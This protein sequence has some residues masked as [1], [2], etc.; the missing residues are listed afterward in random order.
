VVL[1]YQDFVPRMVESAGFLKPAQFETFDAAVEAAGRWIEENQIEVV[2]LETVVLP[3]IWHPY[4]EGSSD[5]SLR[6]SGEMSSTWHQFL[7][8]WYRTVE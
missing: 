2:T 4:E 8:C 6:A 1:R 3:N 5:P 7:R